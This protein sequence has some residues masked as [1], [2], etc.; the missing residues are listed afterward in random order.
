[1]KSCVVLILFLCFAHIYLIF[2][3]VSSKVIAQYQVPPEVVVVLKHIN[4]ACKYMT[5][6]PAWMAAMY[7]PS[8]PQ[9]SAGEAA[10]TSMSLEEMLTRS[11]GEEEEGR[12]LRDSGG[13][14]GGTVSSFSYQ[15]SKASEDWQAW[16]LA[17]SV[18]PALMETI[19]S[20]C[21]AAA[22]ATLLCSPAL[23]SVLCT[24]SNQIC[25]YNHIEAT[26]LTL[27]MC[28]Q[29]SARVGVSDGQIRHSRGLGGL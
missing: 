24:I 15:V 12:H 29:A 4:S 25:N 16:A 3:G 9:H 22:Y 28:V 5:V 8:T 11:L 20:G 27:V 23:R 18:H 19:Y 2:C 1:L 6:T 26:C 13:G 17:S 14:G 10:G 21:V 7:L